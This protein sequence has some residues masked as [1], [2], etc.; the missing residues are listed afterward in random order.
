MGRPGAAAQH[1]GDAGMQRIVDLLGRDEMDMGIHPPR[2]QD[3]PLAR[4][5][6]GPRADDHVDARLRIGIAG[7]ADPGDPPVAQADIGLEDPRPVHDQGVGDD[8]VHRPTRAGDL[9]LAHAIADDLAAA[10][11]HLFAIARG[12]GPAGR[13]FGDQVAFHLDDQVGIA[14]TKPVAHGGTIHVGIGGARDGKGH[15]ITPEGGGMAGPG[16][17]APLTD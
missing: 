8:R 17:A 11:L 16:R 6:L 9:A 15:R 10:E 5:D 1:G 14:Q 12:I 2:R 7:L 3:A 13:A 4:D